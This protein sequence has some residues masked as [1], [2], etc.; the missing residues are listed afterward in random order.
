[1]A[2]NG[3][4]TAKAATDSSDRATELLKEFVN[5]CHPLENEHRLL[6]LVDERTGARYCECH[7]LGSQIMAL[8]TTDVPL[9]P[10]EQPEYKA[11]RDIEEGSVVFQKMKE[12]AKQ[13]RSF[14]NIVAEW[15][16]DST[17]IKSPLQVIGG[18][19]RFEAIRYAVDADVDVYHGVKVYFA[20]DMQQR[21][22][23][24]L[25]SNTNIDVS[26]DLID[27]LRETAKGANLRNWCHSVGL[28]EK[29]HDFTDS[30]LR[31]GPI[32]VRM[33]T[34]FI[35]NYFNGRA[36]DAKNFA[37][38]ET[39]PMVYKPGGSDEL[40][41]ETKKKNPK[42]WTDDG[43]NTAAKEFAALIAA[44]RAAFKDGRRSGQ[45]VKA[46][47]PEKA[48]NLAILSAW[49]YVAGVL[50]N[51]TVRLKRH[52]DLKNA[53]G[54]DPL[55][56]AQLATGKHWT[57]PPNYRGLGYR[58]DPQERGRFAELFFIQ[59]DDGKGITKSSINIAI[60]QYHAKQA[61]LDVADAKAKAE[62]EE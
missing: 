55:N 36:I 16:K 30:Y 52:F 56:A 17:D 15:K 5:E 3:A 26:G 38:V 7:I 58:Y 14:S 11:N 48:M 10:E 33:A 21:L 23:V 59:A 62:Q 4:V 34:T 27:R 39:T 8:G 37:N 47:Y 25:I 51:N 32:S 57:D 49:A 22:D 31:G 46:D 13:K 9:D 29:G 45:R 43:L 44:Q 35:T 18:Q 6:L 54:H 53:R 40:W 28:L 20:L 2:R 41:E 61:Q 24:Q 12:D 50:H 60:K 1:M 19:H 42:L